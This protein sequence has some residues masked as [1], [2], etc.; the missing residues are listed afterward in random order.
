MSK[1]EFLNKINNVNNINERLKAAFLFA[2]E[3][4]YILKKDNRR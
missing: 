4:E 2:V 3:I 1:E